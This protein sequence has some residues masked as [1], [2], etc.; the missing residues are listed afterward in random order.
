MS[1]LRIPLGPDRHPNETTCVRVESSGGSTTTTSGKKWS[2]AFIECKL[3]VQGSAWITSYLNQPVV[4]ATNTRRRVHGKTTAGTFA[5]VR[6]MDDDVV[7][8]GQYPPIFPLIQ[9]AKTRADYRK[10]FEGCYRR[11]SDFA[12]LLLVSSSSARFLASECGVELYPTLS[13]RGNIIVDGDDLEPWAEETWSRV[14]IRG[15]GELPALVLHTIKACPRCTVPCRDQTTGKFLFQ[16]DSLKLW[17]VLK[18]CFPRK[19]S[20]PEWGSWAG[21]Y[22]GIYMGHNCNG[23]GEKRKIAVGDMI[24]PLTILPWDAHLRNVWYTRE[25]MFAVVLVI[26]VVIARVMHQDS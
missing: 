9:R 5:L 11:L 2:L 19:F 23:K 4:A 1:Q 18:A 14:E 8:L 17:N 22:M 3:H 6:S 12:P 13:F 26:A 10:R 24:Y 25:L 20:D 21:V 16:S 7:D 15:D